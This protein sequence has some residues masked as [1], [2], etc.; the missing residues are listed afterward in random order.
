M[1]SHCPADEIQVWSAELPKIDGAATGDWATLNPEEQARADRFRFPGDRD[2]FVQC[3]SWL[4]QVLATY[5]EQPPDRIRLAYGESG[6]PRLAEPGPLDLRFNLSHSGTRAVLAVTR[7]REVG[8]DIEALRPIEDAIAERFFAPG[9]VAVLRSLPVTEREAAFFRCWTR[10][11]AFIKALGDGFS[12]ALDSFEVAFRPGA[13]PAILS[14]DGDPAE[15][16]RWKVAD[17]APGL[18]FAG[19]LASPTRDWT[20]RW[21]EPDRR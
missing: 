5:L 14:V 13:E 1:P 8:I 19:A 11:E 4:R 7:G 16:A 21:A 12:R 10:K 15:G 20:L 2:F 18:G 3:R 17:L 9:E 6:K